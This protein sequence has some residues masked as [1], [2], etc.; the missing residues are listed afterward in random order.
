M[1][2]LVLDGVSVHLSH[3][4]ASILALDRVT[5]DVAA[6]E[7]VVVQG[8]RRSGR[9]ALL[10][11]A[12][13][14]LRPESGRVTVAGRDPSQHRLLGR[15]IGWVY[16]R[17]DAAHGPR[18][19]DQVAFPLLT[20]T[21]RARARKAALGHL[22]SMGV[23]NLA[24]LHPHECQHYE[25][26]LLGLARATITRPRLLLL[27]EPVTGISA[28]LE[29]SFLGLLR[30]LALEGVAVLATAEEF[31][32]GPDRTLVIDR[33]RVT[34]RTQPPDADVVPLRSPA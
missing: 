10:R 14:T 6:G 5:L 2:L 26:L 32:V 29:D 24:E 8:S 19:V 27:D 25:L 16:P 4:R 18:L 12:G 22:D 11:V 30:S 21:S 15:E 34:G 33:G 7:L 20:H 17:A 28:E 13:G 3:A 1:S 31:L 23:G 9:T